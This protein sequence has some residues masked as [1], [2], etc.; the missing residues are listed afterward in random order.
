[1]LLSLVAIAAYVHCPSLS[2]PWV[3]ILLCVVLENILKAS[4]GFEGCVEW[5]CTGCGDYSGVREVFLDGFDQFEACV[6]LI[7]CEV[8]FSHA[9]Y[10]GLHVGEV[11]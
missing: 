10:I 8:M 2:L 3:V 9:N 4:S 1:M 11:I 5:D 6:G 7:N